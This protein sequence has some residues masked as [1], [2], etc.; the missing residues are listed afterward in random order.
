MKV[1]T[2]QKN[3]W[4][5]IKSV[6]IRKFIALIKGKKHI[7]FGGKLSLFIDNMIFHAENPMEYK[8]AT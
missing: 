5:A 1:K 3:L 2:Q 7:K 6:I 4:D 8:K